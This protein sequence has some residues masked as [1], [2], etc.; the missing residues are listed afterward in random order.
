[1]KRWQG[2]HVHTDPSGAPPNR[3]FPIPLTWLSGDRYD[4]ADNLVAAANE[5]ASLLVIFARGEATDAELAVGY[6][7][8]AVVRGT[9]TP[10]LLWPGGLGEEGDCAEAER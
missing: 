7:T 4:I 9:E 10:V 5:G 1:M 2:L 6:V 3:D 8:E